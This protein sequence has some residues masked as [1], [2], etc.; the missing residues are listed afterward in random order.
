MSWGIKNNLFFHSLYKEKCRVF[1]EGLLDFVYIDEQQKG[2]KTSR[3]QFY[4]TDN[5]NDPIL[6]CYDFLDV[7]PIS[8]R[9]IVS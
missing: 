8:W 7:Y 4:L 9:N 2:G 3:D 5:K 1:D 6:A